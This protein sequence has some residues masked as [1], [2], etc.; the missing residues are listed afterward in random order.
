MINLNL[1]YPNV[2]V[3]IVPSVPNYSPPPLDTLN[4][5]ATVEQINNATVNYSVGDTVL[6]KLNPGT[7]S[8]INNSIQYFIIDEHNIF[9]KLDDAVVNVNKI[10]DF[11]FDFTFE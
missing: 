11:T 4:F 9:S 5:T 1:Q 8:F 2:L 3:R 10:F 7:T 6:F